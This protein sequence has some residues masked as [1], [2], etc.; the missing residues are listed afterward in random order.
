MAERGFEALARL[1]VEEAREGLITPQPIAHT[2]K[3][4]S[5]VQGA[6]SPV[7]EVERPRNHRQL[8]QSLEQMREQYAPYLRNY[9]PAYEEKRRVF[10]L[11]EFLLD[12]KTPVTIPHYDGPIGNAFKSYT[13]E[14]ELPQFDGQAVYFCCG[15]ADY[16][17]TVYINGT[18]VGIHEGFF[19][20][21]EYEITR[22]AV[23]GKNKL[24]IVLENDYSML[25][26]SVDMDSTAPVYQ[27]DKIY[28][29][30]GL[31]YDDPQ[32]GW[33]HCPPGMGLYRTVSIEIRNTLH[34][35]DLFIRPDLEKQ[36][37][38][39]WVEVENT[40]YDTIPIQ[41][42]FSL[43]GQNFS[44]T[45]FE[46]KK[47]TPLFMGHE[48][49]V[50]HGRHYYQIPLE[51]PDPRLWWPQ[52][53]WLYRMQVSVLREDVVCDTISRQFGMR[54]FSQDRTQ[55]PKGMYY[56]NGQPIRLRGANTMGFEQWDVVRGDFDQLV[57]DI[58]LAKL[59][60]MNFWRITQ[61]PVQD[62]VYEYCDKLGFMTQCDFPLF[63]MVRRNKACECMRQVEEM[64][65]LVRN[66]PCNVV[67]TYIN[68]VSRDA[69]YEPHRHMLHAELEDLFET[70]DHI[71]HFHHPD[72][73]TK[74]VDGDFDPPFKN[75]MP[76][77][78]C[79]TLW[80]N[81][82]QQDYGMLVRGYGQKVPPDWYYGCGEYGAEG[83]DSMEVMRQCYP[84]KWM[85]EPFHPGN[86]HC[87]QIKYLHCSFMDTQDTLEDWLEATQE[88]QAFAMKTMTEAYRRDPRVVS[89][90]IHL[91]IDAWPAGWLKS[92]MDCKR[93][94]KKAYFASRDALAPLL[95]SLRSDRFTVYSGETVSIEAHA[96]NDFNT[97]AQPGTK[98]VFQ[99]YHDGKM[100]KHGSMPVAYDPNTVTYLADVQFQA[101][102][103]RDREVLTLKAFLVAPD[104]QTL[105]DQ[106]FS[107]TVFADVEIPEDPQ[108]VWIDKLENG[109]HEIAGETVTVA[110]CPR[111]PP[112]FLSRKTG[113]PAVAEF[114]PKD[115]WMWYDRNADRL[116]P[117]AKQCFRAE[118]FRPVLICN[119]SYETWQVVGEK[120]YQGKR[121]VICLADLRFENP[122]AK[123][124][125]RNLHM[126]K[127]IW[128]N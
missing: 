122:A 114:K 96:C 51:I 27:G 41:L 10:P 48:M 81:G 126:E 25:G 93:I 87:G 101:P 35:T 68:E 7:A 115:F 8:K 65:R 60:N 100:C 46:D 88:H 85:A 44:Q 106:T 120:M 77:V 24:E 50:K 20:P 21:F 80:Y 128:E 2:L 6:E 66:H 90:A 84:A 91:F 5:L 86:I 76:D 54:S 61:R 59:C 33:H 121:Y 64:V 69:R 108:L 118:G 4:C 40:T 9:A 73:V 94:P 47:V 57:D 49:P 97:P 125:S 127:E 3:V 104:G 23:P 14:F 89:N 110:D 124:L 17:A 102:Y 36:S 107:I 99:L 75:T 74:H 28:A 63:G 113:H 12:G 58:L 98:L 53:P 79:Y 103:V 30:T 83:M 82:G 19:S 78:H 16:I 56:L 1:K 72:A 43:Y 62:E 70:F 116:T 34:V 92:I 37:V 26:Y 13:T 112:Y 109:Q 71:V 29:A 42:S 15:G 123:R 111:R 55:S 38:T 39:A 95:L 119:G 32:E 67:I 22:Y 45:V 11:K 52:T 18:C 31:G 117:L 105:A